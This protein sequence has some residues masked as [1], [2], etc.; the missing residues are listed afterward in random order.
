MDLP[1]QYAQASIKTA[2]NLRTIAQSLVVRDLS[3]LSLPQIDAVVEQVAQMVP[4][5]NV[6]GVILSG[7]ARLPERHLPPQRAKRDL[8]MLFAGVESFVDKAV[9]AA[10]FAGPAAVIWGYQN[11][12]KL[13]GKDPDDAFPDG[14]WQFYVEYAL[15]DDTARHTNESHG[16]QTALDH[17]RI[18][19]SPADRLAAWSM[20]AIYTLHQYPRLLENEWRERAALS[21]LAEVTAGTEHAAKFAKI[22]RQWDGKRPYGRGAEAGTLDY[23]AYRRDLFDRFLSLA[24]A[25]LPEELRAEWQRQLA[26]KEQSELPAYQRQMSIL[27]ALEP[28]SYNEERAPIALIDSAV[29]V[30]YQGIYWLVPACRPDPEQVRATAAAV[31]SARR[32]AVD[33]LAPLA[34][35]RRAALPALVKKLSGPVRASIDALKTA[36]ILINL[37]AP[38]SHPALPLARVRQVERGIGSHPLTIIDLGKSMAFD[39]SHIFF[40]GAWGSALAEIMTNEALS[41]AVYFHQTPAAACAPA[42]RAVAP[43]LTKGDLDLIAAAPKVTAEAS[44]ENESA[45]LKSILALRKLFKQRSDLIQLTVNDL[46][47]LYRAIHAATYRPSPELLRELNTLAARPETAEA[48][49]AALSALAPSRDNPAVLIPIDAS[50]QS[51]RERLYPLNFEVPLG[52]LDL[53][54]L[55]R[56]C[57][58][59]LEGYKLERGGRD[60][61]GEAYQNFDGLQ[62]RYLATLAGFG[63]V[64]S[65]AKEIALRGEAA[66]VGTIKMLAY[67]PPALQRMLDQIPGRIDVLNDLVKGREVFSNVGSVALGST[68]VRFITAKDDN[69]KKTLAWGVLT[70]ASGTMRISLR[71]FRPHVGLLAAAG[72]AATADRIAQHYLDAYTAGLNLFVRELQRITMASR[73]TRLA[74]RAELG[75]G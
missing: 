56:R 74:N 24:C 5:G 14:T 22:A 7:L 30:I 19:L 42:V 73:E 62:R 26:E 4:A 51:P 72:C 64:L 37:D 59:A 13:A 67:M 23:P 43:R 6:P 12:L 29:G 38:H 69:E 20:A 9:Y 18:A 8:H 70:D 33:A 27:A 75:E 58:E 35:A 16:F 44:A 49:K 53:V 28:G 31:L 21:L 3:C 55:H 71:D 25:D 48:A 45:N 34:S 54:G 52:E 60:E 46:L 15:R 63:S 11:L 41:W 65:R 17:Y 40:D 39:Q 68:L 10:V 1:Q 47:I 2:D 57:L 66:S 36:P 50:Q 61:R 32:E